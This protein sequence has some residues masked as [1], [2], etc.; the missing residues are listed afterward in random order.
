MARAPRRLPPGILLLPSGNYRVRYLGPDGKR[1][2]K[3]FTHLQDAR[4]WQASEQRLIDQD[5]W[6]PPEVRQRRQDSAALTVAEWAEQR[7]LAWSTRSR[8]P[9]VGSTV[10]DYRR[11]L[12]LRI[13]GWLGDT[14]SHSSLPRS[15][16]SG[17]RLS[18]TH[19]P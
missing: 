15:C 9:I 17:T 14:P 4:Y 8:S 18:R 7:I 6:T 10:E 11:C 19:R 3:T 12:R 1:Y 2:S 16:A 5:G 13:D